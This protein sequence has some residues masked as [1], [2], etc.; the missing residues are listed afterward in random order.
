MDFEDVVLLGSV[1]QNVRSSTL[2]TN[3]AGIRDCI[4]AWRNGEPWVPTPIL[5]RSGRP[6]RPLTVAPPGPPFSL[7]PSLSPYPFPPGP[8]R[9]PLSYPVPPSRTP[10]AGLRPQEAA[11]EEATTVS[12]AVA[13]PYNAEWEKPPSGPQTPLANFPEDT[14]AEAPPVGIASP[15][16]FFVT[17]PDKGQDASQPTSGTPVSLAPGAVGGFVGTP[18]TPS[19]P[20]DLGWAKKGKRKPKCKCY[21]LEST[22]PVGPVE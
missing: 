2:T 8:R 7:E 14:P 18:Q 6:P 16:S 22:A 3:G 17:S 9:N 4:Q 19:G 5:V 11:S 1:R 12:V 21:G 13:E 20:G 15:S 10:V